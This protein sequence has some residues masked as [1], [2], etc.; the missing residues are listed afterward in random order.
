[1]SL[2][3][4]QVRFTPHSTYYN[5]FFLLRTSVTIGGQPAVINCISGKL[6]L[7]CRYPELSVAFPS[8]S[9][10]V[11]EILQKYGVLN[12]G[13]FYCED[14]PLF[15]VGFSSEYMLRKFL[16]LRSRVQ[17]EL[18]SLISSSLTG[19]QGAAK[20]TALKAPFKTSMQADLFLVQPD[21]VKVE[22][23]IVPVTLENCSACMSLWKDSELFDFGSIY[24]VH[25]FDPSTLPGG[26]I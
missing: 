18:A 2:T 12:V 15:Q 1:M 4:S 6:T 9:I 11:E 17:S 22:G 24:R 20:P 19:V 3:S 7:G 23:R 14:A 5:N 8:V 21:P 26:G 25:R 16:R 10:R 13:N